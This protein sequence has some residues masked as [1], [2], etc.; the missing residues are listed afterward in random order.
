L[1]VVAVQAV[2]NAAFNGRKEPIFVGGFHFE[3][4]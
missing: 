4:K 3:V 2:V 1:G